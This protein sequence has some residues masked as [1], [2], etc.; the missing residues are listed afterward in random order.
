MLKDKPEMKVSAMTTLRPVHD[1]NY[2]IERDCT[3]CALHAPCL[4]IACTEAT[5]LYRS[6]EAA[7][8]CA[9]LTESASEQGCLSTTYPGELLLYPTVAAPTGTTRE[10]SRSTK[11]RVRTYVIFR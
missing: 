3:A 4:R 9:A 10:F 2:E 7:L 6:E 5:S 8:P 11:L 1:A